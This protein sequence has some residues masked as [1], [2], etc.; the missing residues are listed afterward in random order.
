MT[1]PPNPFTSI[2]FSCG[3][4]RRPSAE[5]MIPLLMSALAVALVAIGGA[6]LGWTA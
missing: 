1:S 5:P 4:R 2:P 6:L 3:L